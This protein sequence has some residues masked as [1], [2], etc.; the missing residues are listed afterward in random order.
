MAN[1]YFKFK[2]FTIYHDK[3]AMK[4]GIDAVLLGSWSSVE[5][6]KTILDIGTGTGIISLMIAQRSTASIDAIEIDYNAVIQAKENV[7]ASPW[8]DRISVSHI[9]LQEFTINNNKK[10]DLIVSNPPYFNNSTKTPD[11]LRTAARHTDT[12]SHEELIQ[13]ATSL[14]NS[15]GKIC[16]IL[17]LDEGLECIKIATNNG[18]YNSKKVIVYPKT[19]AK[20]KRIL[21][22]FRLEKS[23]TIDSELTIESEI[24]H[25]YTNEFSTLVKSFYLKL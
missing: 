9:S 12:L 8:H 22:E 1:P 16:L 15:N 2:Q 19:K 5:N 3:C 13:N 17:P 11:N 10:Y 14:L 25:Q 20:A 23:P 7:S 18:L 21:L 6:C 4:V 24:R